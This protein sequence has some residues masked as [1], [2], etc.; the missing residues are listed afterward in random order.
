MK[1]G[2]ITFPYHDQT[3]SRRGSKIMCFIGNFSDSMKKDKGK[4]LCVTIWLA[5]LH[6]QILQ[7]SEISKDHSVSYQDFQQQKSMAELL[8]R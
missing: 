6:H 7:N 8:D 1:L 4:P 2:Q 5:Q 3:I